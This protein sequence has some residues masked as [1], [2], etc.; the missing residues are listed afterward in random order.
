MTFSFEDGTGNL[1]S[2]T[3]MDSQTEDFTYD[4]LDRLTSVSGSNYQT[5][6]YDPNGNQDYKSG[7]GYLSYGTAHPHAAIGATNDGDIPST[8]QSIS[9][10]PFGKILS[11]TEGN[12][13]MDFTYGPDEERWKTELTNGNSLVRTTIYGDNYEQVTD[14]NG[15]TRHIYYLDGAVYVLDDGAT[16]GRLYFAFTD[17]L[18]SITRLYSEYGNEVF[19]AEYDAWGKQTVTVDSLDFRRGYT[20]HEMMPEFGLINMNGRLYDPVLGRFLSPDNYVQ[21]PD[22]SQSFN[23]YSYCLNNPLKYTDPSGELFGID[24]AIIIGICIAGAANV[25]ANWDEIQ[26]DWWH[27][28][29]SFFIGVGS[30][31]L[32]IVNPILGAAA[33]G[34]S[35]SI[36]NQLYNGNIDWEQVGLSTGMSL[37]TYGIGQKIGSLIDTSVSKI[38]SKVK[39]VVVEK[40]LNGAIDGT[41]GGFTLGTL[42][43]LGNG[44]NVGNALENG[45][46]NAIEGFIIGS[47]NG[48]NQGYHLKETLKS[49]HILPSGFKSFEDFKKVYGRAG[50]GM[51]WHHIVEQ[52]DANIKQFG[53]EKIHNIDNMIALP[54]DVHR[55]ISGHYS[56]IQPESEHMRVRD[57]LNGKS[58][59]FQYEY[60]LQLLKRYGY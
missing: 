44:E 37:L 30:T 33:L 53:P 58:Y 51:E 55:K 60:G 56:S 20:G 43:S 29:A 21:L 59:E 40:W 52:R 50:D 17:H 45:G 5:F 14:A 31:A 19:A 3:G 57:W 2:R 23:R 8:P 13:T 46:K 49:E 34:T 22:F 26:H 35:N 18:G 28:V 25:W 16:S 36:V 9:Y 12:N 39:N 10:T 11:I 38:T 1:L 42:F 15:Q 4:C 48:L 47:M 41:I 7:A 32:G 24:D 54:A 6:T 27:G